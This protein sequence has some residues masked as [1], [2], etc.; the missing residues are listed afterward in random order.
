MVSWKPPQ[1]HHNVI[2]SSLAVGNKSVVTRGQV[3]LDG[4]RLTLTAILETSASPIRRLVLPSI[5]LLSYGGGKK[6]GSS[7]PNRFLIVNMDAFG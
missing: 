7:L 6:I 3:I 4:V 1:N 2:S 5:R